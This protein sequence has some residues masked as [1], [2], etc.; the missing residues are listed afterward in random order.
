MS[1]FRVISPATIG[2]V[3]PGFD[4]LGLCLDGLGDRLEGRAASKVMIGAITGRQKDKLPT[5]PTKNSATIAAKYLLEKLGYNGGIE[6]SIHRSL[7]LSGGL[8]ASA[9]SAVGGALLAAA[10]LN[11]EDDKNLI[12][13]SALVGETF[14]AGKHLDNI[15]PCLFGGLTLVRSLEPIDIVQVP[16]KVPWWL[17]VYTPDAELDTK[18]ARTVLDVSLPTQKWVHQVAH[19]SGLVQAFITGDEHLF[20]KC[21]DDQF[22]EPARASLINHFYSI[23]K[24]AMVQGAMGCSIS[25]GGP[26]VFA[27]SSSQS[28][29]LGV[30]EAMLNA[31]GGGSVHSGA[32]CLSGAQLETV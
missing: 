5:D 31:G 30:S 19:T 12:L 3:G 14:V 17:S 10:L 15:A 27:M 13:E 7:P 21:F 29:A 32:I 23:K 20:R 4:C 18:K 1:K 26:S 8:G 6:I 9:S 11:R 24:A 2:N 25:G 28:I 22:A 16:T